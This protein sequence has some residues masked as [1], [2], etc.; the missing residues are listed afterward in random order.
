MKKVDLATTTLI[1]TTYAGESAG[2]WIAAS[3]L[4]GITLG[5]GGLTIR[6]NIKF[7]EIVKNLSIDNIVKDATCDF[8][9]TS[10]LTITERILEPEEFQV[11]LELCKK[12][13]RSD[14]ESE[15][16]GFSVHDNLPPNFQSFLLA[17]VAEKVSAQQ[18][19]T[20]WQGATA[21]TGEY[22]GFE[23]LLTAD[24]DLP[25][26]NEISG[27]TFTA[28]NVQAELRKLTDGIV[29]NVYS[30]QED[31]FLYVS[32]NIYR[33]FI[34]SLGGFGASGLGSA[35]INSQGPIQTFGPLSFDGIPLFRTAGMSDNVAIAARKSNLWYGTGLLNDS[36]EVKILQMSEID[37]S[38]NI[39]V[40]L[41]FTAGV[42]YGNV[43]DISTIGITNG[44]N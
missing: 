30:N 43:A 41:R 31:L 18:E 9:D 39:R 40:I 12:T 2:E 22:D 3:L 11:N 34:E 29:D 35:G 27:T 20:I 25:S 5:N 6:P 17:H 14:W 19:N 38:Q 4:N 24:A 33:L 13:F 21:T 8:Q 32:Q 37:G 36:Q 23:T 44:N 26:A 10:T 28:S 1:T 42:Q 16:M 15:S 7:K